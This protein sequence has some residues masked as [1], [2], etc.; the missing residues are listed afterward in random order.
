M[1]ALISL[2]LVGCGNKE[3]KTITP[4]PNIN[5][6]NIDGL[7]VAGRASINVVV[8]E[9]TVAKIFKSI[10]AAF[11]Q[12]A[13]ANPISQPVTVVL[14]PNT[15]MTMSSANFVTPPL[16]NEV[17]SF[18][19]L[20]LTALSTNDLR[21]CPTNQGKKCTKAILRVYTSGVDGAG[22]YNTED[23]Y[24]VPLLATGVNPE[25]EVGLGAENSYIVQQ[26]TIPTNK[27][28]IRLSDFSQTLINVNGD[29]SNAGAGTYSTTINVEFALA[30]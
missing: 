4:L 20:E 25:A 9:N 23:G 1:I 7:V 5:E 28:T 6:P 16:S 11:I 19:F 3:S 13:Y 15:T 14:A 27:N 8:G 22:F 24:G 29:F 17:L 12:M 18:G 26:I 30:P 2:V 21:K 10:Q